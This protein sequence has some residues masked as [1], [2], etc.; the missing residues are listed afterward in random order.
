MTVSSFFSMFVLSA[1]ALIL[2]GVPSSIFQIS[3]QSPAFSWRLCIKKH[4]FPQDIPR[5]GKWMKQPK[6]YRGTQLGWISVDFTDVT[7]FPTATIRSHDIQDGQHF[8]A[9]GC[10][11]LDRSSR[12]LCSVPTV[13][14]GTVPNSARAEG[15]WLMRRF[16]RRNWWSQWAFNF[17]LFKIK[18]EGFLLCWVEGSLA[19]VQFLVTVLGSCGELKSDNEG[20][21]CDPMHSPGIGRFKNTINKMYCTCIHGW[22]YD[23]DMINLYE[24]WVW[25]SQ[26]HE[27]PNYPDNPQLKWHKI[28]VTP[29]W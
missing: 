25:I 27:V 26:I 24:V 14:C 17:F 6:S 12:S 18:M 4:P 23:I 15:W 9:L 1:H 10:G 3:R 8:V 29:L 16:F 7:P 13:G 19:M 2:K 20:W 5:Q 28:A 11:E 22:I 21:W